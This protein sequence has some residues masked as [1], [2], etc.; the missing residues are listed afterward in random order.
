MRSA[1]IGF[2]VV[3]VAGLVALTGVALGRQTSLVYSLGVRPA[4]PAVE[5]P[6]NGRACQGPVRAPRGVDFDRIGF[7]LDTAGKPGPALRVEVR[8]AGT[9]RR[10]G[11]GRVAAG[12][13]DS[14]AVDPVERLVDVGSIRA[15]APMDLCLV[16]EGR[17]PVTVIGQAGVASPVT[18]ATL[19]GKPLETDITFNL[20]DGGSSLAA[21]L[22]DIA[23]RAARFRAGWVTPLVYLLLAL[24]IVVLAPVL[25][26]RGLARA[27]TADR[28]G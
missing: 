9:D 6:A 26:A 28:R 8:E 17:Q 3:F 10:L 14:F 11:T 24:G 23:E 2:A 12:Y 20:H 21:R 4:I 27:D 5:L 22:P 18:S 16:N 1:A 7:L 13:T 19:N 15:E 25:L